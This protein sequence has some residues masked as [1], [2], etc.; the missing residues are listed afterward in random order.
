LFLAWPKMPAGA[1]PASGRLMRVPVSGGPPEAVS[2][3]KGYPG[4]TQ[5]PRELAGMRVL[6]TLGYPDVRCPAVEGRPCILAE[7]D[8]RKVSFST[9]DARRGKSG[10]VATLEVQGASFWDLSPD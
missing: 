9:F 4:S 3:I 6:T 5:I 7:G 10:E 8:S 1:P 2:E